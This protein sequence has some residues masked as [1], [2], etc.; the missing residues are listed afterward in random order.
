MPLSGGQLVIELKLDVADVDPVARNEPVFA[1]R[2][3][4]GVVDLGHVPGIEVG[5]E[6]VVALLVDLGMPAADSVGIEDDVTVL[7]RPADH[8]LVVLQL[9]DLTDCLAVGALQ[10]SHCPCSP[11]SPTR[12][13]QMTG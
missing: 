6:E 7:G 5:D 3:E 10:E 2:D 8:G 13:V 11:P 1:S 12:P 4:L 9:D